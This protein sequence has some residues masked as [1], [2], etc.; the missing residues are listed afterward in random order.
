MHIKHLF[1]Y[2]LFKTESACKEFEIISN[3]GILEVHPMVLGT[4]T[5]YDYFINDRVVYE[6]SVHEEIYLFSV[7]HDNESVDGTWMVCFVLVT[8]VQ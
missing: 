4:Y 8:F 2:S 7:E 6:H 1:S 3:G 5:L